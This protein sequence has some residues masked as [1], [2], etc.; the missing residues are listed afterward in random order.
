MPGIHAAQA[1]RHRE[2]D[3][4]AVL[5]RRGLWV[6]ILAGAASLGFG[7]LGMFATNHSKAAS[8]PTGA[9][10]GASTSPSTGDTPTQEAPPQRPQGPRPAS[11]V[12]HHPKPSASLLFS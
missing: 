2:I 10:T 6:V 5:A 8:R 1:A 4:R 11:H 7:V 9:F 3:L 12:T